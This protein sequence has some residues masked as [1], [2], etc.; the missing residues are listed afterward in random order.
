MVWLGKE[1]NYG[2]GGGEI[3]G[4]DFNFG[5]VIKWVFDFEFFLKFFYF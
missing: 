3:L 2:L 4:L 5:G 1:E